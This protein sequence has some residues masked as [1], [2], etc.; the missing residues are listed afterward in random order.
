MGGYGSKKKV[1]TEL[2]S[3]YSTH[4]G[5]VTSAHDRAPVRGVPLMRV[6]ECSNEQ[7]TMEKDEEGERNDESE[8][9]RRLGGERIQAAS[10]DLSSSS[11]SLR[12]PLFF[13]F[14]SSL[15]LEEPTPMIRRQPVFSVSSLASLQTTS[16]DPSASPRHH[17]G[18][19]PEY[20]SVSSPVASSGR[21]WYG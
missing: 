13:L 11:S 3:P 7:E 21:P 12:R 6:N 14:L 15:L 9:N 19:A 2:Q 20:S 18:P 4:H 16:V 17:N 5:S 8:R 1:A 10:G